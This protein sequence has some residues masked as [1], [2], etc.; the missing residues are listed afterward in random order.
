VPVPRH[1]SLVEY[2][3]D[4]IYSLKGDAP[5]FSEAIPCFIRERRIHDVLPVA[6][7]RFYIG[8]SELFDSAFVKTVSRLSAA[9]CTTWIMQEVPDFPLDVP[10]AL[11]GACLFHGNMDKVSSSI[12]TYRREVVAENEEFSKLTGSK[13][14]LLDPTLYLTQ[15]GICS[16]ALDGN[17]LY[18]P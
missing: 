13:V 11:A 16:T 6:R 7:W 10:K 15:N 3:P 8:Q 5:A 18:L 12:D 14:I 1:T 4:G 17:A 9:G 2:V